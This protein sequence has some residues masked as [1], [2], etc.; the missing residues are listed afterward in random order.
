VKTP[1]DFVISAIRVSGAEVESAGAIVNVIA[2]LGMPVYGMQTPN[3][4]SM[5]ADP[6]NNSA[7][8]IARLNFALALSSNRVVGVKVDWDKL[9]E[10]TEGNKLLGE[11]NPA[12]KESELESTLLHFSVSDRTRDTVMAQVTSDPAQ[13]QASLKQVA[14]V[15]RKRDPLALGT[16][17]LRGAVPLP[18]DTQAALAAGLLFGSPE[19]QRR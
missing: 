19:F 14:V 16:P 5:K 4:Y 17:G 3:G 2:D 7:S 9:L 10:T 8:L 12:E 1:Q 13:Q 6:W 18:A 15:D 11:L